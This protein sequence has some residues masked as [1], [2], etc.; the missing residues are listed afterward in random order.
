M[1]TI[2]FKHIFKLFILIPITKFQTLKKVIG[3]LNFTVV[4]HDFERTIHRKSRIFKSE[5]DNDRNSIFPPK[6][7]ESGCKSNTKGVVLLGVKNWNKTFPLVFYA[8]SVATRTPFLSPVNLSGH[9]SFSGGKEGQI[10]NIR[11]HRREEEFFLHKV[12]KLI[13]NYVETDELNKAVLLD[14]WS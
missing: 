12:F 3:K 1:R 8:V 2:S 10:N 11:I 4:L 13:I 14:L 9:L 6:S 5:F 7:D